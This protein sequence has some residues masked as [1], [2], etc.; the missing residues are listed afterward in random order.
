VVWHLTLCVRA[1]PAVE[2]MWGRTQLWGRKVLRARQHSC[3]GT[4]L[5]HEGMW[6]T[7]GAPLGMAAVMMIL[8]L[9]APPHPTPTSPSDHAST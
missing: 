4:I 8:L 5:L 9:L 6:E 1:L 7:R 2:R 3:H